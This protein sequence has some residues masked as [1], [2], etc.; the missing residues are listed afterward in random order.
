MNANRQTQGLPQQALQLWGVEAVSA[1]NASIQQE[2]GDVESVAALQDG[3]AVDVD[4][5]YGR[6]CG[7][8]GQGAQLGQHL[9]TQLTVVTMDDCQT[10]CIGG[11][12][13][14][15]LLMMRAGLH[16]VGYEAHRRGRHFAYCR[17]LVTVD[18]CREGGRGADTRGFV[19]GGLIGRGVEMRLFLDE[20]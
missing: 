9:V 18:E 15:G 6:E 5:V 13:K 10:W 8:S 1:D 17:H 12:V 11:H 3:I 16:G 14:A 2:N 20:H 7:R 19:H 4:D